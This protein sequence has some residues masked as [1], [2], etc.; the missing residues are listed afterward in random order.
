MLVSESPH[1]QIQ[2]G[3]ANN[4]LSWQIQLIKDFSIPSF[5]QVPKENKCGIYPGLIRKGEMAAD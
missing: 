5:P 2:A 3:P 1:I 4:F